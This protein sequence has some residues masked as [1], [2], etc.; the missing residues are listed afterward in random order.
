MGL[1][2]DGVWQDGATTRSDRRALRAPATLPQLGHAGRQPRAHRRRRLSRRARALSSLCLARLPLGAPHPDLPQAQEARRRDLD[3]GGRADQ[4]RARLAV[5]D[6]PGTIADTVNG[7][8]ELSDI[9][10]LADPATP[11]ASRCRCCGTRSAAP[12][13]TTSRPRSSACSTPLRPLHQRTHRLLSG[14]AARRDRRVNAR[15]YD[16]VN[17]GVYRAGFA[18]TQEAYEE[19][20]RALFAR[21]TSWSSAWRASAISRGKPSPKPTGGCSPRWCAS[22]RSITATSNA[23]CAASPTTRTCRT[24]CAISTS[25]RASPRPSTSTTSSATI[26]AASARQSDRHRAARP[27]ARLHGAA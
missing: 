18:T 23:I 10:L 1:L 22:T 16:N 4:W 26:T 27:A 11:A 14:A 9:Y 24:I 5:R 3:V 20:F 25:G 6:R 17:N 8:S 2:V 7:T 19:A 15:V 21:S 12:S 13:S